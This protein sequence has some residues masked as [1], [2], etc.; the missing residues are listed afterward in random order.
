MNGG[1]T[2]D[3]VE[4]GPEERLR[5]VAI[6]RFP[7]TKVAVYRHRGDPALIGES[8]LRFIEWRRAHGLSPASSATY[9]ILYSPP[10]VAPDDY[11]IDLCAAVEGEIDTGSSDITIS[12]LPAGRCAVL[13][14]VGA[15][16]T[17]RDSVLYLLTI[18]FPQSGERHRDFPVFLQRVRFFPEVPAAEAVIDIFL[19]LA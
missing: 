10:D 3:G 2:P 1:D 6:V 11:R 13:R 8:I 9:N 4:P 16:E 19:P 14:H 7:E 12:S 18:W 15:D 17:L 5:E